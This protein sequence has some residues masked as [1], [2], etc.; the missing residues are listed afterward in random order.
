MGFPEGLWFSHKVVIVWVAWMSLFKRHSSGEE[1]EKNDSGG[2][3]IDGLTI[4]QSRA[5]D[6]V[7][8]LLELSFPEEISHGL[9]DSFPR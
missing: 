1:C 6:I 4:V 7:E 2:E 5:R 9:F 3:K 8:I